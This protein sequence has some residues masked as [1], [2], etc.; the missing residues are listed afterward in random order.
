MRSHTFSGRLAQARALAHALLQCAFMSLRTLFQS[1]VLATL[2]VGCAAENP[3]TPSSSAAGSGGSSDAS[4]GAPAETAACPSVFKGAGED[5][6]AF[7][8]GF[9]CADDSVGPCG[10]GQSIVCRGGKWVHQE[11]FPMPCY[12]VPAAA[13]E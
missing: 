4:A 8:E 10:F 9:V 11:T 1:V 7:G 2:T 12:G 3:G 6:G 5:C 13:Q